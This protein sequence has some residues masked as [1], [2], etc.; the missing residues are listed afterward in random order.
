M[1]SSSLPGV[2][3]VVL[4][5]TLIPGLQTVLER[6]F[7]S[8]DYW[9][10]AVIVALLSAIAKAVEVWARREYPDLLDEEITPE[11]DI[12]PMTLAAPPGRWRRWLL[13]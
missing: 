6:F 12:Q 9:Y 4:L 3:W 2:V 13:G 7:P 1:S 11:A 8:T 10:S 5:L